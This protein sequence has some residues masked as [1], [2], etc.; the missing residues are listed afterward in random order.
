[1]VWHDGWV[2]TWH[3]MVV[4]S[5][6]EKPKLNFFLAIFGFGLGFEG[7]KENPNRHGSKGG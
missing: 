6:L 5:S 1:M 2:L 3:C 4:G 7:L